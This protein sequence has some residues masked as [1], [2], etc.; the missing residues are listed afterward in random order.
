[1][2]VH[3]VD[4]AYDKGA[5]NLFRLRLRGLD[6]TSRDGCRDSAWCAQLGL[7]DVDVEHAKCYN[8]KKVW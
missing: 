5:Q 4:E 6:A 7:M 1:M 2:S 8:K 3:Q